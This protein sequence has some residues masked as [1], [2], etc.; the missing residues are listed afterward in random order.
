MLNNEYEQMSLIELTKLWSITER[1]IEL[2]L[3]KYQLMRQELINRI[4]T[5]VDDENFNNRF[6]EV[7]N[8][9]KTLK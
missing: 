2:L 7:E 1:K 9:S 4:P 3:F 8:E 6:I 5:L